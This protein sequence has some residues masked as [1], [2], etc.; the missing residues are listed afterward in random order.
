MITRGDPADEMS[1]LRREGGEI[2]VQGR[3]H[4]MIAKNEMKNKGPLKKSVFIYESAFGVYK[5]TIEKR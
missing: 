4:M 5:V 1:E 2:E 3:W